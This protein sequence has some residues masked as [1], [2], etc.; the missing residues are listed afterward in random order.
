MRHEGVKRMVV[1]F[2]GDNRWVREEGFTSSLA[3]FS[4]FD[5]QPWERLRSA[6]DGQLKLRDE[7]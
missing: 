6:Y 3:A 2:A 4:A 1:G 7:H 5:G